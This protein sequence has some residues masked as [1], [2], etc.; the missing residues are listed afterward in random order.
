[1]GAMTLAVQ[2][3]AAADIDD[4][5]H[6]VL[7]TLGE[8]HEAPPRGERVS[9]RFDLKSHFSGARVQLTLYEEG[10]LAVSD[11]YRGTRRASRTLDLSYLDPRPRISR[12]LSKRLL[13][14][15]AFAAASAG[16]LMGLADVGVLPGVVCLPPAF[17]LGAAAGTFGWLFLCRSGEQSVFR[18]RNGHAEVLVLFATFG[19]IRRLRRI[20]PA[21]VKA[22]RETGRSQ[23]DKNASLRGEMREHYR[24]AEAGAISE[25]ECAT[26]TQ[27]ILHHFG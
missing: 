19:S 4:G 10:L 12:V 5:S 26:C 11:D 1:M 21:I 6:I 25:E 14:L 22:I 15:C 9:A 27:R 2:S 7:E 16:I 23:T 17:A 20:V 24:L 3:R 13:Y 8:T 18:T